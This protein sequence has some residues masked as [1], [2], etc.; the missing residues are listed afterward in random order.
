MRLLHWLCPLL[1]AA[2][3]A[4]AGCG[5]KANHESPVKDYP[6]DAKVVDVAP[7]R[8]AVTL[9]HKDI[10]GLMSAMK[11]KFSVADPKVLEGVEPGD[12]VEGRLKAEGGKYVVTQ[13][14]KR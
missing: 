7:D 1:L 2:P 10:P 8:T 5:Q 9:D 4:L 11:M 6:I 13:L 14:K 12:Q 3:L